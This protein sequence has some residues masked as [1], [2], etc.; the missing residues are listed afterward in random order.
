MTM[1]KISAMTGVAT[2]KISPNFQSINMAAMTAP[3]AKNG[4]LMTK[5]MSSATACCN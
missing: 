2:S 1:Y 5:R 3:I 4:A